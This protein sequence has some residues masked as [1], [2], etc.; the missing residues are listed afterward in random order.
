MGKYNKKW[1]HYPDEV[2][3][4]GTVCWCIVEGEEKRRKLQFDWVYG[5]VWDFD[6]ADY[7]HTVIDWD[8][9]WIEVE[10]GE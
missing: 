6:E 5:W 2:P 4:T 7:P 8:L 1:H 3:K 10:Y 9:D